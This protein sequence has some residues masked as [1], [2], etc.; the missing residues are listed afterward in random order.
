MNVGEEALKK[1]KKLTDNEY[2]ISQLKTY[3]ER[4]E[5]EYKELVNKIQEI[6]SYETLFKLKSD[7]LEEY[8]FFQKYINIIDMVSNK[9]R[10]NIFDKENEVK[11]VLGLKDRMR[12]L[13]DI[14]NLLDNVHTA[15]TIQYVE[16]LFKEFKKKALR[17]TKETSGYNIKF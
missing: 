5:K 15:E 13:A 7:I 10:I 14:K 9:K 12:A 2:L 6:K 16:Y 1:L 11:K 17:K 8:V 3:K 4:Y